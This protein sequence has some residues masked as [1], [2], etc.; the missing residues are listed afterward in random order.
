MK[1]TVMPQ[2]RA[3]TRQPPCANKSRGL[4]AC[5]ALKYREKPTQ[6][7]SRSSC[8]LFLQIYYN[9]TR[10]INR[11]SNWFTPTGPFLIICWRGLPLL[12]FAS[13]KKH[14]GL[15]EYDKSYST[16]WLYTIRN[17]VVIVIWQFKIHGATHKSKRFQPGSKGWNYMLLRSA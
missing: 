14:G 1:G 11:F 16:N 12:M 5:K 4:Y 17:Q 6:W 9:Y 13:K 2:D 15:G 10:I 8:I 7:I 3:W